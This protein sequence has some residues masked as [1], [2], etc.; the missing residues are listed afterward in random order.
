MRPSSRG[1]GRRAGGAVLNGE[2]F[3]GSPG[4]DG[5]AVVD[6]ITSTEISKTEIVNSRS[7][8]LGQVVSKCPCRRC[9]CRHCHQYVPRLWVQSSGSAAAKRNPI[10]LEEPEALSNTPEMLP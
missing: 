5:L 3:S 4:V 2:R 6:D 8:Q 9:K 1:S 7:R 10:G